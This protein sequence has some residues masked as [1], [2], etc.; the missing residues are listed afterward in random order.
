MLPQET[1]L[2]RMASSKLRRASACNR[3]SNYTDVEVQNSAPFYKA[4][5]RNSALRRRGPQ[6]ILDIDGI[7]VTAKSRSQT[8]RAARYC[9]RRHLGLEDAGGGNWYPATG[10]LDTL[11]GMP[12]EAVRG[13]KRRRNISFL[14]GGCPGTLAPI[15]IH[16]GALVTPA[17]ES[18][19]ALEFILR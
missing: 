8:L 14:S 13:D 5:N 7:G 10:N 11:D 4:V 9:V 2:R 12:S 17:I 15:I 6:V 1:A 3:S 19:P 18:G 16:S